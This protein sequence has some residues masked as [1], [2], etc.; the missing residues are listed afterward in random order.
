MSRVSKAARILFAASAMAFAFLLVCSLAVFMASGIDAANKVW[1]G[2][3][4]I[5][6]WVVALMICIC[7]QAHN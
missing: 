3:Y 5:V 6:A 7:Y 1:S 4:P 2:I